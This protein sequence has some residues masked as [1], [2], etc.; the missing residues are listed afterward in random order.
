M[1]QPANFPDEPYYADRFE[2][3]ADLDAQ[4]FAFFEQARTVH[5]DQPIV[6]RIDPISG[7]H[8]SWQLFAYAKP[9]A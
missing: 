7:K 6:V 1:T 3:P 5:G 4:F 8:L 2:L 9:A